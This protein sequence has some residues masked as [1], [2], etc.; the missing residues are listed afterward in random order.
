MIQIRTC[1]QIWRLQPKSFCAVWR[2]QLTERPGRGIDMEYR[3][4]AGVPTAVSK[5]EMDIDEEDLDLL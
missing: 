4:V 2:S 3:A 1:S 5:D